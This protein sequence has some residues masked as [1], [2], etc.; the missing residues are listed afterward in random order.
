MW[1]TEPDPEFERQTAKF[2]NLMQYSVEKVIKK[3]K[4]RYSP[5][6]IRKL[7]VDFAATN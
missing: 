3:A 7:V 5:E 1:T 6:P 2:K 4:Q